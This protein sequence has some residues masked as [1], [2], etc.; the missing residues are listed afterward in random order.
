M[1]FKSY[2]HCNVLLFAMSYSPSILVGDHNLCRDKKGTKMVEMIVLLGRQIGFV[3]YM[4]ISTL[5]PILMWGPYFTRGYQIASELHGPC[6]RPNSLALI[7]RPT[8]VGG[9]YI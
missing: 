5:A 6:G 7:G 1:V 2:V 4:H 9:T 3:S 8:R